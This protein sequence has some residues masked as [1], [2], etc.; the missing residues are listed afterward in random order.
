[1]LISES[2]WKG[3]EKLFCMAA[4]AACEL[5]NCARGVTHIGVQCCIQSLWTTELCEKGYTNW[6]LG[7]HPQPVKYRIVREGLQK[8]GSRAESIAC[9]LANWARGVTKVVIYHCIHNLWTSELCERGLQK[10]GPRAAPTA[11]ELANWARV[12]INVARGVTT[13]IYIYIDIWYHIYIYI[14]REREIDR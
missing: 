7:L 3:S 14:Y 13:H 6:D 10:L 9:E 11:C 12:V 1:M 2:V 5:A 4:C 8:L